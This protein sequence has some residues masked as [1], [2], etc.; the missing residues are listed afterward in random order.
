MIRVSLAGS[1]RQRLGVRA[2]MASH[3][4]AD[5]DFALEVLGRG[6]VAVGL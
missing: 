6:K 5:I 1:I 2:V 3:M 4:D